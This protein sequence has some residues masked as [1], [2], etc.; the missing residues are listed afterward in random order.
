MAWISTPLFRSA[1]VTEPKELFTTTGLLEGRKTSS[2]LLMMRQSLLILPVG[3]G[4][5]SGIAAGNG[6][7]LSVDLRKELFLLANGSRRRS[8][9]SLVTICLEV[10]PDTVTAP[11]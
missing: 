7:Q 6:F 11:S 9:R 10:V 5:G 1:T 2:E 3:G 8:R 4:G